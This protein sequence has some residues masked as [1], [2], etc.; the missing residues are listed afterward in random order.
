[1]IT[2]FALMRCVHVLTGSIWAG[3]AILMA[4]Y[5]LPA[6]QAAGPGPGGA[7]VLRQLTTVR[8]LP[9]TLLTVAALTILSGIYLVWLA[10]TGSHDGWFASRVGLGYTFGGV[11][12]LIAFLIGALINNPTA[13]RIG[14][15]T[16][17]AQASGGITPEHNE[18]LRRLT[19]RLLSP[20]A[21]T[22]FT[23]TPLPG[24]PGGP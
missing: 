17:A 8:K 13:N 7:A 11:T 24:A 12:A 23:P 3:A 14:V 6:A 9:Q 10:S 22:T 15:L 18:M 1:M 21:S 19:V 16:R 4:L 20:L 5:V 2:S